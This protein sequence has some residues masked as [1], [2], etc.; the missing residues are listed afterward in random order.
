MKV[1]IVGGGRSGHAIE[2]ALVGRGVQVQLFSRSTGFDILSVDA[3]E[4]LGQVDAIVEA[5]GLFTTSK[6]VATGFFT[7]STRAVGTAARTAGAKHVLLSIVNCEKPELQ[8][9]G[10]FAGKAEQERVARE[11]NPN[12][13]IIR[14]TQWFEFAEQNLDRF[15]VG[16]FALILA[17]KIQP[18]A[19]AAVAEVI[20]DSIVGARTGTSYD[21]AGPEVTTLAEMTKRIRRKRLLQIPLAIPGA[22][23][24][25]F[26][27]GGLLPGAEIEKIGPRFSEWLAIK[28]GGK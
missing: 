6:K 9:Y 21:V 8:G 10:Y 20:A 15:S 4:K 27:D 28:E 23:W 26:R 2:R 3:A 5:T 12:V 16:P 11:A 22:T 13:T 25:E 18:V 17:M 14:S 7:R 1:A 19:L 24:R